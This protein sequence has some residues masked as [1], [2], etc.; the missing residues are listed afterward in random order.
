MKVFNIDKKIAE[1][2]IIDKEKKIAAA[3]QAID[4]ATEK[5]EEACKALKAAE[6]AFYT[7]IGEQKN[8]YGNSFEMIENKQKEILGN[9]RYCVDIYS[10]AVYKVEASITPCKPSVLH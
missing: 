1:K 4:V 6:Q 10:K 2:N 3:N 7:L 8:I 5:V 9:I